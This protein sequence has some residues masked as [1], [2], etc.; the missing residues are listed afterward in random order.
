MLALA[1]YSTG[2]STSSPL[3][4]MVSIQTMSWVSAATCSAVRDTPSDR[5][6]ASLLAMALFIRY[7]NMA[8]SEVR[9]SRKR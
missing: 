2:T 9:P 5:F 4:C 6:N 7:L 3:T 1:R 8:S